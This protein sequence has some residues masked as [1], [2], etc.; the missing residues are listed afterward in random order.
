MAD[1]TEEFRK[2]HAKAERALSDE[3]LQGVRKVLLRR[4]PKKAPEDPFA[5]K[6]RGVEKDLQRAISDAR[7]AL[8]DAFDKMD[9]P[10][11]TAADLNRAGDTLT[12][13]DAELLAVASRVKALQAVVRAADEQLAKRT[14]HN[15]G[16]QVLEH[17]FNA[18]AVLADLAGKHRVCFALGKEELQRHRGMLVGFLKSGVL[19]TP[20]LG[21]GASAGT[22]AV[23]V[24][25]RN[26]TVHAGGVGSIA[27]I[28]S[29]AKA[30]EV[31]KRAAKGVRGAADAA[32]SSVVAAGTNAFKMALSAA[33]GAT[34]GAHDG[35]ASASQP[36]PQPDK[37]GSAFAES[38][39]E[40]RRDELV[41]EHAAL[42]VQQKRSSAQEAKQVE[43]AVH[44]VSVMNAIM[45][46]QVALQ[47]EQ[48]AL[49]ERNTDS[50]HDNLVAAAGEL[51]KPLS[52]RWNAKRTLAA[53]LYGCSAFLLF[54]NWALR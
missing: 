13:C 23:S 43:A 38:L 50:S 37:W 4:R 30:A 12:A 44:E 34:K 31:T 17:N 15:E 3:E 26:K 39:S 14:R 36:Q 6:R 52:A 40:E 24:S 16:R 8:A 33:G 11:S 35:A 46:E 22:S 10:S 41:Q 2:L 25:L 29:A 45:A 49:V 5:D 53:T 51:K 20:G 1:R 19:L 32:S 54:A 7:T 47:A 27:S 28:A 9:D 48:L 21:D 18:L 42:L